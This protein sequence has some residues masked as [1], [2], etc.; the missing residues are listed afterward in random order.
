MP[1]YIIKSQTGTFAPGTQPEGFKT[2]TALENRLFMVDCP[3]PP[4]SEFV[5]EFPAELH[6]AF[7]LYPYANGKKLPFDPFFGAVQFGNEVDNK[8]RRAIQYTEE[9]LSAR[10]TVMKWLMINVWIPDKARMYDTPTEIVGLYIAQVNALT[11]DVAART[12]LQKNLY[13]NL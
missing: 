6:A 5:V 10:L 4:N 7:V 8:N 1:R 12:Y 11:D 3:T 13:Y 9:Q 2:F